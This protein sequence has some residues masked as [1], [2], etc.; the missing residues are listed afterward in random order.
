MKAI[1]TISLTCGVWMLLSVLAPT[2]ATRASASSGLPPGGA[3]QVSASQKTSAESRTEV[4]IDNFTFTPGSIIVKAGTQVT[5]INHDDIPHT[6]DSTEGKFRSSALDTDDK[7]DFRFTQPGEYP[8]Y[9]RIHPKM[10]GKIVVQ[11]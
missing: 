1:R 8:F 11:P 2:T 9:C 7:F 10:T 4:Q 5:W 6:V 3:R